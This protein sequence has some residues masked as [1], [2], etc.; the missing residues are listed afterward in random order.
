MGPCRSPFTSGEILLRWPESEG[1][2]GMDHAERVAPAASGR[3]VFFGGGLIQ[4][5]RGKAGG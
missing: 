4:A 2:P 5:K 3:V 1:T